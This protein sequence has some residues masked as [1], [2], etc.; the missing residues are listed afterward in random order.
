MGRR[1]TVE[2]RRI[3]DILIHMEGHAPQLNIGPV[4]KT[5]LWL[6]VLLLLALI[7]ALGSI[8]QFLVLACIRLAYPFELE[9]MEGASIDQIRWIMQGK[10]LYDAPSVSFIPAFYNFLYYYVSA[11]LMRVTGI[12]F[13]APRLVSI[14]STLGCFLMLFLIV[15]RESKRPV[16][17]FVAAGVYAAAFRFAGAWMD[18][19]RT[20]SLCLFLVLAG[21]LV[22]Q[23]YLNR[24][25]MVVSALLY[26][27]AYYTKQSALFIVLVIAPL[28]LVTSN[29]R[30]WFQ[31]AIVAV[32]GLGIFVALDTA[33]GGWYS[34]Y[35]FDMATYRTHDQDIWFFWRSLISAMW[36][37]LMVTLLYAIANWQPIVE[38]PRRSGLWQHLGLGCALLLSTVLWRIFAIRTLTSRSACPASRRSQPTDDKMALANR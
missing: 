22:S 3:T 19:S 35:T 8:L 13:V 26:V 21:F 17:G 6:R 16:A 28:S 29:W 25:G 10:T 1:A 38:S 20:D 24:W 12:G 31:W 27:L 5:P 2:S 32:V 23:Q 11:A 36:P 33:S 34:F 15:S 30:T 7:L 18:M 14:L 4:A 9:W 37:A